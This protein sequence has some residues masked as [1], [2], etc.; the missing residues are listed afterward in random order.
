MGTRHEV[1][2]KSST[3][4]SARQ[5]VPRAGN[6][7]V[8]A[9]MAILVLPM[10]ML[11]LAIGTAGPAAAVGGVSSAV[12]GTNGFPIWYQDSAGNRVEQCLDPNDANC[13]VLA[14]ATYNPANPTVFPSNFPDEFFYA[15][16]DSDTVATP[17][18]LGTAPG[19]ASVRIALEGA[20]I[21]GAP[22]AADRMVF[23]RIRVKVTSG[24]CPNTA[25]QFRHPFGTITLTTNAAG[26]IPANVGTEDIGCVPTPAKACNFNTATT[27]RV[28]GTSAAGGFLRWD[29]DFAPAAPAGYLGDGAATL[30]PVIGGTNGNAFRIL[31][32]TGV[33]TGMGTSLF[34]VAG[35]LAGSLLATPEPLD[36]GGIALGSASAPKTVN[37]TN[38][39]RAAVTLGTPTLSSTEFS[40]A[41]GNCAVGRSLTRDASCSY[42][43]RFTPTGLAGRRAATLT[44][45]S[46][47]GVRSP[48]VINLTAAA[49]NVGDAPTLSLSSASMSF[50]NVRLR[51]ASPLQHL[52]VTNT[53]RAPLGITDVSFDPATAPEPDQYRVL[54]DTCSTGAFVD[55]GLSC[56][57]DLQ[58]APFV[59]GVHG[60]RILISSNAG[61]GLDTVT[62]TIPRSLAP[63]GK[64]FAR[65]HAVK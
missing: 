40:L 61:S 6:R 62:V 38:V 36:L 30:H 49:T 9:L 10:A 46:T 17:G 42:S 35:K 24:L 34:G 2:V 18:C 31:S 5:V 59:N 51:T 57:I 21:N 65:V 14:S 29:P 25:Y 52:V 53:G 3:S 28:F 13:V 4:Y 44:I 54:G 22:A 37:I 58:F 1:W 27:S 19:R 56:T 20:F 60:T 63:S 47:G 55:P 33:D 12:S 8:R 43:V 7:W 16:A 45:P 48:L 32:S 23:G 11:G 50:G 41:G 26:A 39:D 64:L 15:L